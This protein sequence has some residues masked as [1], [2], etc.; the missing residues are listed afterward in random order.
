M[1]EHLKN[2]D[3]C[4]ICGLEDSVCDC[5]SGP[6]DTRTWDDIE[7]LDLPKMHSMEPDKFD[8]PDYNDFT[9]GAFDESFH[10]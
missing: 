6:R 2:V 8:D 3:V 10:I 7:D 4:V 5:P 9:E 1:T